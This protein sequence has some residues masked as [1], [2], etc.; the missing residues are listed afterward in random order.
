MALQISENKGIFHLEG[1]LNS[2]T[3]RSFIIH[4]EHIIN[5]IKNVK[6]NIDKIKDIDESGVSA[7]KTLIAIALR[8]NKLFYIVGDSSKDIYEDYSYSNVA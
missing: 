6:I 2:S 1:S 4:F 7:F 3:T 8:N 5:T